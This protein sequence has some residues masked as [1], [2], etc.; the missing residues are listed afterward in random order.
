MTVNKFLSD[1]FVM[2]YELGGLVILLLVGA[3]ISAK[4]KRRTFIAVLM[5]FVELFCY[6]AERWT[7]TFPSYSVL[8]PL[9]TATLYSIYPA[10]IIVMMLIISTNMSRKRFV[11]ILIP[12]MVC[13]PLFY[14]SQWT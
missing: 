6:V 2:I 14:T 13:V 3:H 1:N 10:I 8:R 5:L 4:M 9:L 12:E 11:L 7:Q